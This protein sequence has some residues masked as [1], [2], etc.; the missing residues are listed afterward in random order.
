ML[1]EAQ[2]A[3]NKAITESYK[4]LRNLLSGNVQYRWIAS[5]ARCTSMTSGLQ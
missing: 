4:Q 5:A 3:H 1:Q 2:K